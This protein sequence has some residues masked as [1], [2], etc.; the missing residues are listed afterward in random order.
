MRLPPVATPNHALA[1]AEPPYARPS[2]RGAFAAL[3]GLLRDERGAAGTEY[4][5]LLGILG[6]VG[7]LGFT[8][9]GTSE[10]RAIAGDADGSGVGA[11]TANATG[12]HAPG[13]QFPGAPSAQA[14]SAESIG[15]EL[16]GDDGR[17]TLD[18]FALNPGAARAAIGA[19]PV[20]SSGTGGGAGT[21]GGTGSGA[22]GGT[23]TAATDDAAN[24]AYRNTVREALQ[25]ILESNHGASIDAGTLPPLSNTTRAAWLRELERAGDAE[26]ASE[27]FVAAHVRFWN[28]HFADQTDMDL[29]NKRAELRSEIRALLANPNRT[30]EQQESLE[31]M[32]FVD[33]AMGAEQRVREHQDGLVE[34]LLRAGGADDPNSQAVL[35]QLREARGERPA[36]NPDLAALDNDGLA[37]ERA[38]IR[39]RLAEMEGLEGPFTKELRDEYQLLLFSDAVYMN[40]QLAR[41]H[42]VVDPKA[43]ISAEQDRRLR[44]TGELY[45]PLGEFVYSDDYAMREKHPVHGDRRMHW[46]MDMSRTPEQK[47]AGILPPIGAAMEG[48]VIFA[49]PAGGAGNKVTIRHP[50]GWQT[51]YLHLSEFRVQVGDHVNMGDTI[52]IMGSTGASTGPHLHFELKTDP[53][54]SPVDPAPYFGISPSQL[55]HVCSRDH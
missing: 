44:M 36:S 37:Q 46:G 24:V 22:G 23:G 27:A 6:L 14:G 19:G 40:E 11:P 3:D 1:N 51:S 4:T 47:A 39:A 7:A 25:L 49:A 33:S 35:A 5:A 43:A 28:G 45:F 50:N 16:R 42:R 8:Q 31:F 34:E 53:N 13:A 55:G 38:A 20:F 9:L 41:G 17:V 48:E 2:K 18:D 21:G 15:A 29:A 52:G 26:Y 32:Q 12:Q 10:R 30:P 54:G